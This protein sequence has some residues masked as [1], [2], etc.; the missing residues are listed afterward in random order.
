MMLIEV[1]NK[2]LI[3]L[4]HK[5]PKK[6]Y[7]KDKNWICPLFNEIEAIFNPK[8]NPLFE[9]G[10]AIRWILKD[11]KGNLIGRIAAFYNLKKANAFD[12]PTGGIGFFECINDKN[13]AFLL[14]DTAKEW[15]KNKGMEAMDGPINFG[16]NQNYW[17]LL[18]DGFMPQGMGMPYN[19]PYYKNLFEKYG[20]KN[21]YEQY[22]YH[23][24]IPDAFPERYEKIIEWV[25]KRKNFTYKHFRF[26]E[27]EKFINDLVSIYNQAWV[28]LKGDFTPLDYNNVLDE[29][30]K[31]RFLLDEKI[32]WFAYHEDEPIAFYV[33]VPDLNQILKHLNGKLN[34][35]GIIKLFYYKKTNA[36]TRLRGI[37]AGTIPKYQNSGV[38]SGIFKNLFLALQN[39]PYTEIE[40]SWI[41][42]YNPKMQSLHENIGAK[43]VKTHITYRYIFDR[44]KP[45][46]RLI[47]I[48]AKE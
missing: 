17:G 4:F 31:A 39:R 40:L 9:E 15:L 5:V 23:R 35:W 12:Y 6:L 41:G 10:D 30:K 2:K 1:D 18:V 36:I 11:S 37:V 14:F 13:A 34:L 21:F 48:P 7:K 44:N 3:N 28:K 29:Y 26:K 33:L 20:F 16:E 43:K 24:Y 38:E 45:F 47:D 19:F 42:D 27:K 25:K 8:T 22:S 46:V 32:I